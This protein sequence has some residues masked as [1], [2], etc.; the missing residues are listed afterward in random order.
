MIPRQRDRR[1]F[2]TTIS[3]NKDRHILPSHSV[4]NAFKK[5]KTMADLPE[6][7]TVH[8]LRHCFATHLL[9]SGVEVCQIKEP[10]ACGQVPKLRV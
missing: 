2:S 7:Y 4:L 10:R 1:A 9:E 6:T 8:T 3:R 5:Y